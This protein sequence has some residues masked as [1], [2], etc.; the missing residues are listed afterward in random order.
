[1]NNAAPTINPDFNFIITDD[2]GDEIEFALYTER[3]SGNVYVIADKDGTFYRSPDCALLH[4]VQRGW[5]ADFEDTTMEM[6]FPDEFQE[7]WI[8]N[9]DMA[10]FLRV[11]DI[12][13]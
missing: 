10:S 11:E 5:W 12:G 8:K 3:T 7:G 6:I 2:D 4:E 9:P 1:M 13:M